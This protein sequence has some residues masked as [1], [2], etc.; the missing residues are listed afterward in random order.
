VKK[1]AGLDFAAEFRTSDGQ[2]PFFFLRTKFGRNH[3]QQ[4]A[5]HAGIGN[6]RGD[7]RAHGA[8]AENDDF[9]DG[10]FHNGLSA[11]SSLPPGRRL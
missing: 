5:P 2:A 7:T 9:F 10:S 8:R 4:R 3:V 11:R 6:M 1:A